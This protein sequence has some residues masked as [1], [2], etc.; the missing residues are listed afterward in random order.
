M[1]GLERLRKMVA[2]ASQQRLGLRHRVK[3]DIE[4]AKK[5]LKSEMNA[6]KRMATHRG[7][8]GLTDFLE[9]K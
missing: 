6:E 5:S 1:G 4:D 7:I 2:E 8:R 3:G 9:G